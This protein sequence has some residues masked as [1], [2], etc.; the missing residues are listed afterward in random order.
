MDNKSHLAHAKILP[1]CLPFQR[2]LQQ[3]FCNLVRM[4]L[5]IQASDIYYTKVSS[6]TTLRSIGL[7][8]LGIY[9]PLRCISLISLLRPSIT[10][11]KSRV[12]KGHPYLSPFSK[13]K[14]GEEAPF[15]LTLK[16]I[17]VMHH[18][19]HFITPKGNPKCVRRILIY[20]QLTRSNA[21]DRS[22]L[23]IIP[24]IIFV[25]IECNTS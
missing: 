2:N 9:L 14:K 10:S 5:G 24:L 18:I 15:I 1:I 21:L 11:R 16:D 13:Q 7:L 20:S 6:R 22:T 8:V 17:L 19:I 4:P 25:C 12:D 23:K 3:R